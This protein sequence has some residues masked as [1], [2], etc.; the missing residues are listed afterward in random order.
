MVSHVGMGQPWIP[1]GRGSQQEYIV[2]QIAI[3]LLGLGAACLASCKVGPDYVQPTASAPDGF[4]AEFE[5]G[6]NAGPAD[7]REWWKMFGD[8][9]LDSLILRGLENNLDIKESLHRVQEARA[10][11]GIARTDLLPTLDATGSFSRIESS[12]ETAAGP[13]SSRVSNLHSVA[14]DTSWEIDLWGRNQRRVEAAQ[15]DLDASVEDT[16]DVLVTVLAEIASN[17]VDLRSA[18][19]RL[20]IARGNVKLQEKT[21]ELTQNQFDANLV[22]QLDV[23]QAKS[24][25]ASTRSAVPPL[26]AGARAAR[27]RLAI[28]LGLFPGELEQELLVQAPIPVPPAEIA[29]GIPANV[30]RQRPDVRRTERQLAAQTARIGVATADLYPRL[31]LAGSIGYEA[32]HADDLFSGGATAF[33]FGPSFSWNLFDRS[34]IRNAIRAEDARTEQA[35]VRYERAILRALEEVENAMT[36]FVRNQ[37]SRDELQL[38]VDNARTAVELSRDQYRQGITSFQSVIDTQSRLFQL[39]DTLSITHANITTDLIALY[40]ALGGGWGSRDMVMKE[41]DTESDAP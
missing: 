5:R 24:N 6:L 20:R 28:L 12:E 31:T 41:V 4:T 22:S 40:K 8:P 2:R 23:A 14:L 32:E 29:V 35:L 33:R 25:L 17:Y 38:A 36:R 19:E 1:A 9:V 26:E 3:T 15:A 16:R 30:V 34:R 21:L 18:Q 11:R 27:N 37:M 10:L 39:E 7:F 13:I